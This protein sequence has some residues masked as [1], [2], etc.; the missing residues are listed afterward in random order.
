MLSPLQ[1][2]ASVAPPPAALSP[3]SAPPALSNMLHVPWAAAVPNQYRLHF[4]HPAPTL[5]PSDSSHIMM[6]AP[7]MMPAGGSWMAYQ[8]R[9]GRPCW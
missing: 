7:A 9:E 3:P 2:R 4:F 5:N 8:D 1:R 6:A